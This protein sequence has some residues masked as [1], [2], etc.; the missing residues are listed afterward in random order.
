M[1]GY[2][3]INDFPNHWNS[4][5][6]AVHKDDI[7]STYAAFSNHLNDKTGNTAYVAEYRLNTRDRGYVW[8]RERAST[9]RNGHGLGLVAA[10]AIRDISDEYAARELHELS[11]KRTDENMHNI[12]NVVDTVNEVVIQLSILSMNATIEAARAGDRGR[13]FSVVAGEVRK[14]ADFTA[15]AMSDMRKMVQ[16]S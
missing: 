16:S 4:W 6:S 1:L 13:S 11:I 8:F 9:L 12:L 7:D 5:V 2:E 15:K 14:L 3:K 10:G